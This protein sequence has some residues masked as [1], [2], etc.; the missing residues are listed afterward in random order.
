MEG[1]SALNQCTHFV[2]WDTGAMLNLLCITSGIGIGY[3]ADKMEHAE[4]VCQCCLGI[5]T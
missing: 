5:G 1:V 4:Y 2:T 3:S